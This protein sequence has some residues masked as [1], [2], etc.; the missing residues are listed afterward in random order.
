MK[1]AS[2]HFQPLHYLHPYPTTTST[3]TCFPAPFPFCGM[4][5]KKASLGQHTSCHTLG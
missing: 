1:F 3:H 5:A 4:S 2:L